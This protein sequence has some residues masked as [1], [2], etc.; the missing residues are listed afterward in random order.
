MNAQQ[1]FPDD[2]NQDVSTS[3]WLGLTPTPDN[4]SIQITTSQATTADETPQSA[5]VTF[6]RAKLTEIHNFIG[7]FLIGAQ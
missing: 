1:F 3:D 6:N 2:A 5:T 4:E 7:Q